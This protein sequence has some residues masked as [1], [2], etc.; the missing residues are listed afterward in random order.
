MRILRPEQA[1]SLRAPAEPAVGRAAAG[2]EFSVGEVFCLYR[3]AECVPIR[4]RD[5]AFML[6][7]SIPYFLTQDAPYQDI[8]LPTRNGGVFIPKLEHRFLTIGR[9][10][11]NGEVLSLCDVPAKALPKDLAAFAEAIRQALLTYYRAYPNA[12]QYF[13]RFDSERVKAL[14][15]I[16]FGQMPAPILERYSL[17]YYPELAEPC[18]GFS[19]VS[20]SL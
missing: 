15:D 19:L 20:K 9:L 17:T 8:L 10:E 2:D 16:V 3:N 11:D 14:L 13:Y 1:A 5:T 4:Y 18:S 12:N 7:F 6:E